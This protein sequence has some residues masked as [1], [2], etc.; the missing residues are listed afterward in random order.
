MKEKDLTYYRLMNLGGFFFY[1]FS[2]LKAAQLLPGENTT[3]I[4]ADSTGQVIRRRFIE[5]P[6]HSIDARLN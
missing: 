2:F 6:Q 1:D 4:V 5:C 3:I